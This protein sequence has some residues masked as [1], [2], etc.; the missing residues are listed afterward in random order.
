M[1]KVNV[2]LSRKL[3]RDYNSTGF[4][5]HL[6][7]EVCVPLDEPELIAAKIQELYDLAELSLN[8]QI[9]RH[10][11]T[12]LASIP[13]TN[14]PPRGSETNGRISHSSRPANPTPPTNPGNRNGDAGK[15]DFIPATNKQIQF[16]MTLGKR[17]GWTKPQLEKEVSGMIGRTAGV[18]DLSK[19]EAGLVLDRLSGDPA[20]SQ[21]RRR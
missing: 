19:Q 3:S 2:G 12:E 17:Q 6:E 5:I 8:E 14:A 4:S 20:E 9:E 16:L 15:S 21:S 18:Y 10:D 11:G 1:L 13:T 7:G